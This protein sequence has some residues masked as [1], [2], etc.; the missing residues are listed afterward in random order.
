MRLSIL[1]P[2]F[3]EA[4]N[5]PALYERLAQAMPLGGVE[6]EWVIVDDHSQDATFSVIEGL[7]ARDPRVRGVRLARHS[8]SHVAIT[9]ALHQAQGGVAVLM[10]ADLQDPPET[11]AAMLERWR[12]GAR[13]VWAVRRK[14][15]GEPGIFPAIYYWIMRNLV[16]MKGMP[17][18][19]ADFFLIDR[20]VIDAFCRCSERNVSVL[21]LITWLG[22][23]QD[24]VEY[25]KQP[26]IRGVSG[27]TLAKKVKLVVDSVVSFSDFPIRLCTYAG[28]ALIVLSAAAGAG[29][30][31]LFPSLGVGVMV[32]LVAMIGLTGVQ[33]LALG[34]VGEYVWRALE[35][36]RGR[37]IYLIEATSGQ[38]PAG[39][40][41]LH[42]AAVE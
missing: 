3:N 12:D 22:F 9:C 18:S 14:K 42:K 21:A 4:G 25:E 11:I 34:A 27:W 6:W 38:T 13:V 23:R 2:A 29:G 19:G 32:V 15:A 17:S 33:L 36:A 10:A 7:A 24:Y 1:T 28:A 30:A 8:G 16:G 31:I 35:E 26:R 5:L 40:P 37:P 41:S 39:R 20:E